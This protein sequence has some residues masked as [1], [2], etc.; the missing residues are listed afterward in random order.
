M[1]RKTTRVLARLLNTLYYCSCYG[2]IEN[3]KIS[4]YAEQWGSQNSYCL[5]DDYDQSLTLT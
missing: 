1:R 3:A 5:E 2:N 4:T